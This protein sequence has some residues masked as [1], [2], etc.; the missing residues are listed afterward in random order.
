MYLKCVINDKNI[1]IM[2]NDSIY[3][4]NLS[5]FHIKE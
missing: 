5:H 1:N 2:N 3:I 4:N